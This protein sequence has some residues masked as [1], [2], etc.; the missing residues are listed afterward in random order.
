[1]KTSTAPA[2]MPGAENGDYTRRRT[3]GARAEVGGGFEKGR[4]EAFERGVHGQDEERQKVVDEPERAP[5][6]RCIR[7]AGA[8]R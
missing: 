2:A 4:V 8:R 1:M 5:R 6:H 3:A 7:A